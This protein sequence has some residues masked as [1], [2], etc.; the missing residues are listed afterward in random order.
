LR[1][2]PISRPFQALQRRPP[3]YYITLLALCQALSLFARDSRVFCTSGVSRKLLR[4]IAPLRHRLSPIAV[5]HMLDILWDL[6]HRA[7]AVVAH[8]GADLLDQT[9][10]ARCAG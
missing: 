1:E 9:P 2:T 3:S 6:R 5:P 10:G 8:I 7:N 4:Y